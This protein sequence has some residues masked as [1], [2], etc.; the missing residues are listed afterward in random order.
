MLYVQSCFPRGVVYGMMCLEQ[1]WDFILN[2]YCNIGGTIWLAIISYSVLG[3]T[4]LV[5]YVSNSITSPSGI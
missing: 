4:R 2:P 3:L 1:A 5:T